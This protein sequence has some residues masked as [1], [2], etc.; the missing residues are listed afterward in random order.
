METFTKV[1][2]TEVLRS[3]TT[4]EVISI[5]ELEERLAGIKNARALDTQREVTLKLT[6]AELEKTNIPF[7]LQNEM[8]RGVTYSGSGFTKSMEDELEAKILEYKRL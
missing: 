4:E 8:M 7:E 3:V 6:Q 1:S 2:P 5:I